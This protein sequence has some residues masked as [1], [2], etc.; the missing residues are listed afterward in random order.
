[1]APKRATTPKKIVGGVSVTPVKSAEKAADSDTLN[2]ADVEGLNDIAMPSAV[3]RTPPPRKT[4][5]AAAA[6]PAKAS[7]A[8]AA[9]PAVETFE[10]LTVQYIRADANAEDK[11]EI[12]FSDEE[13]GIGSN[14]IVLGAPKEIESE[15]D[16]SEED[17]TLNRIGDV[18]LEWYEGLDHIGYDID[19]KRVMRPTQS[20]LDELIGET[21]DPNKLRT[22][23]DP[24]TGQKIVLTNADL[25]TL[26]NMQRN[27]AP[28]PA[29]AATAYDADRMPDSTVD[30]DP[31][32]HP[33]ARSGPSKKTFVPRLHEMK[34]LQKMIRRMLAE[35][36]R[37]R[38]NPSAEDEEEKKKAAGG[39]ELSDLW[40]DGANT[41]LD[42][43]ARFRLLHRVPKPAAA[44]PGTYESYRP[45]PE[46]LP[47]DKAKT[48]QQKLRLIDRKEHFLPQ[49]FNS[50]RHVPFYHHMIQDAYQRCL[51]LCMFP[52]M[53]RTRLVVDPEKLLPEL[54][55]PKDLRPYPEKLAFCYKGHTGTVRS[56]S[57]SP[58]G[59]YLA[60]AC[61]DHMLRVFEITNGRLMKR[62]DMGGVIHHVEFSPSKTLNV[63]VAA[64]EFSLVFLVPPFCAHP[65]IS[66]HTIRT[67]R[68]PAARLADAVKQAGKGGDDDDEDDAAEAGVGS[69]L[70]HGTTQAKI[71]TDETAYEGNR[72]LDD[73]TEKER[74]ADF[75]DATAKE[76]AAGIVVKVVMHARVKTFTFHAKGDYICA[77]CPKDH[78][79][80]RQTIMLQISV[81]KVFCPFRKFNEV[82][83]DCRFHPSSPLFFLATTNSVRC[84]NLLAHKMQRRYKCQGGITTCLDVHAEGDNFLV[85]DTTHHTLWFDT[86]FS[87]KPYKKLKSHRGV[88]NAVQY[89]KRPGVYPLFAT[90]SS[91]GQVHIMHGMVYDDYNKSALIVPLK[92]LKH[93]SAIY[94]LN[95][96]PTLPWLFTGT[97]D[98]TVCCWTE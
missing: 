88:L 8:P 1:M 98:G 41:V 56:M 87:D 84:Y 33:F 16:D 10:N 96:H 7:P 9:A 62:Y 85:G 65:S 80:Y 5:A 77:L 91:D 11:E 6:S 82:V 29:Y 71:D 69:A 57:V 21:D 54:P 97:E 31:L 26:F 3:K 67:L 23:V 75:I 89:H 27:R 48:L 25:A 34:K 72:D 36:E 12:D 24:Q 94:C 15:S 92:I 51:D 70:G 73:E 42:S 44:P 95:W 76:R 74:R 46:Y 14:N 83:T 40:E 47:T 30:F 55:N 19:G 64:V 79:K 45:P 28:N 58:N 61:D 17:A 39:E 63:L 4:A 20:A 43:R 35:D 18:P 68:A 78:V 90:G 2:P 86:D 37:R 53:T 52:R 49:Q 66:E 38:L 59:Q 22:I 93:K 50:L 60:T 13:E 32:N 81:R